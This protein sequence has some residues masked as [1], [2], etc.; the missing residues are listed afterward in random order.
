MN[1]LLAVVPDSVLYLDAGLCIRALN[2]NGVDE[3][4]AHDG[5]DRLVGTCILDLA[6]PDERSRVAAYYEEAR[7]SLS[8]QTFQV[9][10]PGA[11]G[12]SAIFESRVIPVVCANAV[13]GFVVH[14][15]NVTRMRQDEFNL[16][17]AVRATSMGLWSFDVIQ[18]KVEWNSEMHEITGCETPVRPAEYVAKLVHP[19]DRE[20]VSL[21]MT[22]ALSKG[23][24]RSDPHRI[25]LSDQR[26]RWVMALGSIEVNAVG[27]P[28]FVHGA[29]IDITE[30]H[31]QER[32]AQAAQKLE[33]V[34]Q[35]AAGIAH[36]FNNLLCVITP[37]LS[38]WAN[39]ATSRQLPLVQDA[40]L[41]AQ[42][43][44]DLVKQ[45]VSFAQ[46]SEN[47]QLKPHDPM[48]VAEES[49]RIAQRLV[50]ATLTVSL[51]ASNVEAIVWAPEG[52]LEQA[53]IN[54]AVNARDAIVDSGRSTGKFTVRVGWSN[55]SPTKL[56]HQ[57]RLVCIE[58]EDDG[59]GM[60]EEVKDRV[61]D[62]FFTTKEPG[63]G[64]GLGLSTAFASISR[65][66]GTIVC[67]SSPG[68]G[69]TFSIFLPGEPGLR[70]RERPAA[71]PE[72]S[73]A[74]ADEASPH[75]L[76]V[77]DED[78]VR[79]ALVS[80]LKRGGSTPTGVSGGAAAL[81]ALRAGTFHVAI[82]DRTMPGMDG[83]ALAKAIRELPRRIPLI[84]L[85]G[86]HVDS[87][88]AGLFDAVLQ[89]PIKQDLLVNTIRSAIRQH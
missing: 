57:G 65:L 70:E 31:H 49:L 71:V 66:G 22:R 50:G 35:L 42:R 44:A 52:Q 8:V 17:L 12:K 46:L 19:E 69:T 33:A 78:L 20:L 3:D 85:T 38:I 37:A 1:A 72:E 58:L 10:V 89:K 53:I 24:F 29:T 16:A 77:D 63:R 27:R 75:V 51:V 59:P 74:K 67:E 81:E 39:S 36:N 18:E 82:I 2:N 80:M 40:Q 28:I 62:P 61:F 86:G 88:D 54:I 56:G 23:G 41:A 11:S 6:P 5:S 84:L 47:E 32:A 45:L 79:R 21:Q 76:V 26:I 87:E 73:S 48:L 15:A 55:A 68:S 4:E 25:V 7:R 9:R 30:Q 34:G 14:A 83:L 43:A 60:T 13:R 64:T